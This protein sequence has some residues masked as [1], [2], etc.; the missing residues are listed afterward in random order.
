ML[1]ASAFARY[2]DLSGNALTPPSAF[3]GLS[4]LTFFGL[5]YNKLVAMPQRF[6]GLPLLR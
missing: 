6:D 4:K 2:L 5:G 1:A 3:E